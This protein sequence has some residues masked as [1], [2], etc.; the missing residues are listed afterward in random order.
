MIQRFEEYNHLSRYIDHVEEYTHVRGLLPGISE[1]QSLPSPTIVC[2]PMPLL[3]IL[4][5]TPKHPMFVPNP[6]PPISSCGSNTCTP[7]EQG[8]LH[9]G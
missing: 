7:R 5:A 9:L 8:N 3:P 4:L 6:G 2:S 1:A